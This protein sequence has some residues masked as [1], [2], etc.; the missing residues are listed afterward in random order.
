MSLSVETLKSLAKRWIILLSGALLLIFI[1]L[2][3][4][5]FIDTPLDI[6]I[7]LAGN[8]DHYIPVLDQLV[9]FTTDFSVYVFA[10]LIVSWQIGYFCSRGSESARIRCSYLFRAF[11][12]LLCVYHWCG[13]FWHGTSL[14]W[15]SGYE[16]K[17]VFFPLGLAFLISFWFAGLSYVRCS[18]ET[19]KKLSYV[20]WLT[21]L[22]VILT[23]PIGEDHIKSIIQ[24]PRPLHEHYAAWNAKIRTIPDEVVRGGYSYISGHSSSLFALVT[25]LFWA[26][27]NKWVRVGLILWAAFHAWTRVYTAAHFPYCITMGSL[28]GFAMGTLVY[29]VF[30]KYDRI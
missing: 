22:T 2:L 18:E 20:F 14:F 29:K 1:T 3:L 8:P 23:N 10:L 15:W 17:S 25:P 26:V 7:L 28:F 30:W 19:L 6:R 5:R 21:L 12:V 9:V 24:R 11:A 27:R 4:G 13:L 16:Y